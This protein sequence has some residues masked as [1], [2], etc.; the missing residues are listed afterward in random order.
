MGKA[1]WTPMVALSFFEFLDLAIA[2]HSKGV[3]PPM[4]AERGRRGRVSSPAICI[5]LAI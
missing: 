4:L 5:G 3:L 2:S 1:I